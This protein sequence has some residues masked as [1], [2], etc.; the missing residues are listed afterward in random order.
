MKAEQLREIIG[1]LRENGEPISQARFGELFGVSDRAVRYWLS[2]ERPIPRPV[3]LY[4]GL[5]VA[6]K[7]DLNTL[8]FPAPCGDSEADREASE[9]SACPARTKLRKPTPHR[10]ARDHSRHKR[11]N[12]ARKHLRTL[13]FRSFAHSKQRFPPL[14][15]KPP[16]IPLDSIFVALAADLRAKVNARL[17]L[18]ETLTRQRGCAVAA[19]G[20][21]RAG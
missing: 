17:K 9:S 12:Q 8:E 15:L 10:G 4:A 7:R 3:Q 16:F 2:G 21:G 20:S 13:A 11:H 5:L 14:R 6:E 18:F 19:R 1:L